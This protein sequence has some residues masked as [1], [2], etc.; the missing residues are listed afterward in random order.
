MNTL[1]EIDELGFS[2]KGQ[3]RTQIYIDSLCIPE[4]SLLAL[5]GASG[6]GKSTILRLISGLLTPHHGTI[7]L[8]GEEITSKAPSARKI[9]MVFQQPILFPYL[10]VLANVAFPLRLGELSKSKARKSAYEYLELVGMSNFSERSV[11]S[12]SGGEAQ[13]VAL[14]R[15]LAAKPQL[16]LLDEPFAALDIDIR[17]EMQELVATLRRELRLTMIL[18]THDQREAGIL[19]DQVAL[20]ENGKILQVGGISDLYRRPISLQVYRAMG[21]V[22]EIEGDIQNGQFHSKIGKLQTQLNNQIQGSAVLTFRQEAAVVCNKT[23]AGVRAL[24]GRVHSIRS[25][26][27]RNELGIEINGQLLLIESNYHPY[28]GEIIAFE[29]NMEECQLIPRDATNQ[30]VSPSIAKDLIHSAIDSFQSSAS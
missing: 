26:G 22:N 24:F 11:H 6:A 1:M 20:L 18:V 15:A 13:R 7:K 14:A 10:D 19:A 21:G 28:L 4:G 9:G 12:L 2:Y 27:F 8:S 16:L 29:L 5:L 23:D 17:A 3:E 30:Q 25:I